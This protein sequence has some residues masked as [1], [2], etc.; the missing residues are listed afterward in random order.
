M[1]NKRLIATSKES[2]RYVKQIALF[3]I[4][5]MLMNVLLVFA[6][7]DFFSDVYCGN[8]RNYLAVIA[9][10]LLV[11]AT[12]AWLKRQ[13]ATLGGKTSSEVK[14]RLRTTIYQKM[15]DIGG[16]Y[17]DKMSTAE[18]VQVAS[19]GVEQLEMYF[20]N[21]LPQFFYCMVAPL[22]LFLLVSGISFKAAFVLF[23]CVP[24]IPISIV[25][26]QKIS[27]K[28]LAKYWGLYTGLG[29]DFLEN[30]QGMTTLKIYG[31]D[32]VYHKQMNQSAENFRKVT[33]KV[34]TMQLNSIIIMDVIAYGGASLGAIIAITELQKGALGFFGACV[35]ILLSAEF[36]LPMRLL[37]SF[38]HVA[39]NGMSASKKMFEILDMKQQ[40]QGKAEIEGQGIAFQNVSFSYDVQ[41][42]ILRD[43]SF[44][45]KQGLTSIVGVSG[46][47]KSTISSL[48]V[49]KL[50][51]YH[52]EIIIGQHALR[53][54][55][56]D[57]LYRNITRV[58][59][60]GYI[61][62]GTVRTNLQMAKPEATMFEMVAVLKR[63]NIWA[64]FEQ[65][66]GLDT[67][68]SE[69]GANLSGG[70]KATLE[71]CKGAAER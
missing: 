18:V 62:E 67:A 50:E 69:R 56:R 54:L 65:Q 43:I 61:F 9:V 4:L 36:F 13:I 20:A 51:G 60:K 28:L 14:V 53:T 55:T 70:R 31:A 29:E 34:L 10:Y 44:V 11:I 16:K 42:T 30:I 27:K 21:Y 38:F 8:S 52:G 15:L 24:L 33:M 23:L 66:N 7:A 46:S 35:I 58:T 1:I 71:H 48:I 22:I 39:M 47:G 41:K 32:E 64:L 6:V 37:G 26:V 25:I 19:E 5:A 45:A 57:S 68:I 2:M 40:V 59:D 3:Q 12:R 17:T 63:A 49:A